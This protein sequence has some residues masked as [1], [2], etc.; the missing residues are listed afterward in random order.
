MQLVD[1][2]AD[3]NPD[4]AAMNTKCA[5]WRCTIEIPADGGV[6]DK[7]LV[8]WRVY[9]SWLYKHEMPNKRTLMG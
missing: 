3:G 5:E 8:G 2:D 6:E 1:N 4:D 7:D 9:V